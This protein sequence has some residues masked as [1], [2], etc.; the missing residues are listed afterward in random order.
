LC[1]NNLLGG[2]FDAPEPEGNFAI[3]SK[4]ILNG[5]LEC[6]KVVFIDSDMVWDNEAMSN[7]L[8]SPFHVT[9]GVYSYK[10]QKHVV[11]KRE[12][13][14]LIS[15]EELKNHKEPFEVLQSG[16]GFMAC[17]FESLSSLSYPWFDVTFLDD[18]NK[19][20]NYLHSSNVI[21]EDVYFC[22]KLREQGY[23]IIVD[24]KIL[25]GHQKS[26]VLEV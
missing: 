24:P 19:Q 9:S 12:G 17:S 18:N 25:V 13:V 1:R 21:T 14:D 22:N 26:I 15:K 5:T 8:S 2:V 10:D 3:H 16:L 6:N 11:L 23:K 7:L 4:K 20:S